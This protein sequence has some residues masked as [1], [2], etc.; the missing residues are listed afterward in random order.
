MLRL[1][2]CLHVRRLFAPQRNRSMQ[3]WSWMRDVV[4]PTAELARWFRW[5]LYLQSEERKPLSCIHRDDRERNNCGIFPMAQD[6]S[7]SPDRMRRELPVGGFFYPKGRRST[8]RHVDCLRH[9]QENVR[10]PSRSAILYSLRRKHSPG[11]F[12]DGIFFGKRVPGG[13]D[14]SCHTVSHSSQKKQSRISTQRYA[15]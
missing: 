8:V 6:G 3:S 5:G 7:G 15:D 2:P 1:Y 12:Q 9:C 10:L 14:G 4:M 13:E 11:K